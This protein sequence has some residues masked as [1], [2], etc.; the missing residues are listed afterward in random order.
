MR[1]TL[2]LTAALVLAAT[3]G[4]ADANVT[5]NID[6]NDTKPIGLMYGYNNIFANIK[7]QFN[8]ATMKAACIESGANL[9]RFPA[10]T[11]GDF[12]DFQHDDF[13]D[14]VLHN[15]AKYGVSHPNW[16]NYA[17]GWINYINSS[18][19]NRGVNH[20]GFAEFRDLIGAVNMNAYPVYMGNISTGPYDAS[21]P[22]G[23]K[24][25][26]YLKASMQILKNQ[27]ISVPY[28]E[29]GNELTTYD[30]QKLCNG[31]DDQNRIITESERAANLIR[32]I[33]GAGNIQFGAFG[34][35]SGAR[36]TGTGDNRDSWNR[37]L[38]QYSPK[39]W[40]D[41]VTMHTY[42][43]MV[44]SGK[45]NEQILRTMMANTQLLTA[46]SYDHWKALFPGKKI[47]MT[48]T[49]I[50]TDAAG[51]ASPLA[52]SVLHTLVEVDY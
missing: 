31:F 19:A 1:I 36:D 27:G 41:A 45:T 17:Q 25:V 7:Y 42:L 47:W 21:S 29:L 3:I 9:M 14:D 12:Y 16:S 52:T 49:G 39:S 22:Y 8:E 40:Y 38:A 23:C 5:V 50:T 46:N 48:E 35:W 13:F 30:L 51:G 44:T 11:L 28:L 37:K 33:F 20:Y 4:Y 18:R 15:P 32:P 24:P 2:V 10:G 6:L 26:D 43:R 34:G